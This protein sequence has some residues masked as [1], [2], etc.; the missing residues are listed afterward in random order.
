MGNSN[1]IDNESHE[2]HWTTYCSGRHRAFLNLTVL[3]DNFN[4]VYLF[5]GNHPDANELGR[6][7]SS[8]F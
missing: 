4:V 3:A 7:C 5:Q 1:D 2:G 8:A 6:P